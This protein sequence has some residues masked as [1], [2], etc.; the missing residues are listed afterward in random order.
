MPP[1]RPQRKA[2]KRKGVPPS[3]QA[4]PTPALRKPTIKINNRPFLPPATASKPAS[5]SA[6]P[7]KPVV[8]SVVTPPPAPAI[9]PAPPHVSKPPKPK[10]PRFSCIIDF[11]VYLDGIEENLSE[12]IQVELPRREAEP[13]PA[14]VKRE[15]VT[16]KLNALIQK[17]QLQKSLRHPE[18][19]WGY[20]GAKTNRSRT[21]VIP[22]EFERFENL[23][24]QSKTQTG[25]VILS[26]GASMNPTDID[27]PP[28]NRPKPKVE[29]ATPT[30][31][32]KRA[33]EDAVPY[34]PSKKRSTPTEKMLQ[35]QKAREQAGVGTYQEYAVLL[36]KRYICEDESCENLAGWCYLDKVDPY[37]YRLLDGDID[38]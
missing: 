37:H 19:W 12:G 38:L 2:A 27:C 6:A 26:Y 29:K 10:T 17:R 23:L 15:W 14:L 13:N 7:A 3:T 5:K 21:I 24:C 34:E 16:V 36:H 11:R 30:P 22:E 9:A 4:S 1:R 18:E 33:Y 31:I 28:E 25:V 35:A 32:V 8:P 20:Y